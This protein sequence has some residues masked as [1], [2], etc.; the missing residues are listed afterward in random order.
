MTH[1][2]APIPKSRLLESFH[3]YENDAPRFNARKL[4]ETYYY[5]CCVTFDGEIWQSYSCRNAGVKQAVTFM[6]GKFDEV[7]EYETQQQPMKV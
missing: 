5:W 4:S 6:N 2:L 1:Q 3:N 7:Y